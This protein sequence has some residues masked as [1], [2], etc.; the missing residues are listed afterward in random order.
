ME[1][2]NIQNVCLYDRNNNRSQFDELYQN[3]YRLGYF[4]SEQS[5]S[6]CY[7]SFLNALKETSNIIGKNKIVLICKF[8]NRRNFQ[9]FIKDHDLNL[10]IYRA[11]D[12]FGL[13]E[14]YNDY[15]IAFMITPDLR[16]ENVIITDK[17][18]HEISNDYLEIMQ[19]K[20]LNR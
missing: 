14:E 4:I 20:I 11:E 2:R 7:K 19:T 3:G 12:D 1:G 15:P 8:G 10:D 16:M 6:A 18:N 13:F 5:C 17:T 9:A